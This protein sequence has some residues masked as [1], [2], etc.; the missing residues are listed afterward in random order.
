MPSQ[1]RAKKEV[2][3]SGEKG[4]KGAAKKAAPKPKAKMPKAAAKKY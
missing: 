1:S 2:M 3:R 4:P